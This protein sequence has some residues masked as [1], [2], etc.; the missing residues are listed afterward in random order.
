M[1]YALR[2]LIA[3]VFLG[4]IFWFIYRDPAN[5]GSPVFMNT[6]GIL[7][8]V[9]GAFW[10]FVPSLVVFVRIRRR[11]AKNLAGFAEW[12]AKKGDGVMTPIVQKSVRI[13]LEKDELVFMHEKGT[14]YVAPKTGFDDISVRGVPGDVAFP[15]M[16]RLSRKI[17]RI[18]FYLTDR[19][20]AFVGKAL[21]VSM[22]FSA[23]RKFTE[24]PGGLVFDVE[25][26]GRELH[27]AFTFQNP[28]IAAEEVRRV[29]S[30]RIS[31]TAVTKP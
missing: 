12:E 11:V 31:R 24:T 14:F 9:F 20:M 7:V 22:P 13:E 1:L 3:F 21:G 28:L 19:R 30:G 17:Q 26:D 27:I 23:V 18:H 6:L 2:K 5:I 25:R 4:G 15:R 10:L 29:L 8:A 16:R